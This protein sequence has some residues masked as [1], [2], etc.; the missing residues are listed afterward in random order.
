MFVT[1]KLGTLTRSKIARPE[2]GIWAS[3]WINCLLQFVG[4]IMMLI[5]SIL[6]VIITHGVQR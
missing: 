1:C 6:L 4:T 3:K 5:D 2:G